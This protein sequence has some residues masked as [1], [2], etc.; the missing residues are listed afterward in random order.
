ML[1]PLPIEVDNRSEIAR[2]TLDGQYIRT[3]VN[4]EPQKDVG[5][6]RLAAA[7]QA[8]VITTIIDG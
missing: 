5:E 1:H 4:S 6:K 7:T 8:Q 3:C 2:I